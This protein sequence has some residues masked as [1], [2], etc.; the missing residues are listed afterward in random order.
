MG[1]IKLLRYKVPK[2]LMWLV[3]ILFLK[4]NTIAILEKSKKNTTY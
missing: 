4:V 1:V 3:D 2:A